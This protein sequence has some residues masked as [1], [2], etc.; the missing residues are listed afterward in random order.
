MNNDNLKPNS[1]RTTQELQDNGR[2]GGIKSAEIR[3]ERKTFKELINIA[4]QEKDN[5]T[6][7]ENAVE[8]VASLINK[9]KQGDSRAFEILRDTI[10]EKPVDK[11]AQTDSNGNDILQPPVIN[12][13]PVEVRQCDW[14]EEKEQEI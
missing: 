5:D 6:G 1:A 4:L 2:K 11:T 8:I 7:Q 14:V 9:A 12:I 3:R 13:L 10:G